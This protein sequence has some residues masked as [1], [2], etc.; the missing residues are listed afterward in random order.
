MG[1]LV[2]FLESEENKH[3]FL[4][5]INF[6]HF[7]FVIR[8]HF[9]AVFL[10]KF[11]IIIQI[12]FCMRSHDLLKN[13]SNL[14]HSSFFH[15]NTEMLSRPKFNASSKGVLPKAFTIEQSHLF[16]IKTPIISNFALTTAQ[17][18]IYHNNKII[19]HKEKYA[20]GCFHRNFYDL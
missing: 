3:F 8:I 1:N 18:N 5:F 9:L 20:K 19:F 17:S 6:F 16:S 2:L 13:I 15:L 4:I 7:S 11:F 10:I 12:N 14:T